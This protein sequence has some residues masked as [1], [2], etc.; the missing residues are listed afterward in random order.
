MS[1]DTMRDLLI[2]E[3]SDLYSAEKQLVKALPKMAKAASTPELKEAFQAH[4]EE[5]RGQVERLDAVFASLDE[6]PKRKK[7]KGMEGL[8]EE[9]NEKCQE[10]GEPAVVDAGIISAAQRVEHYEIAAYGAAVAFAEECGEAE[11]A[12]LLQATLDEEK[13]ADRTLNAIAEGTVNARAESA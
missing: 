12:A 10:E 3:L 8:I 13:A 6:T 2:D 4:L 11:A 1:L 7:C 9:G 5:T